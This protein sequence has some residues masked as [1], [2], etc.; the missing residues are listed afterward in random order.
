MKYQFD[1]RGAWVVVLARFI[2]ASR[3]TTITVAGMMHMNYWKFIAATASRIANSANATICRLV[4]SG[5]SAS[6][7][8]C[9]TSCALNRP[10]DG[11]CCGGLGL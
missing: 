3:T 10:S 2:P 9:G 4:D 11:G 1:V 7:I 5:K 6:K 8:N